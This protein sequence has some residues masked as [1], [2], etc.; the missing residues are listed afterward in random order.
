MSSLQGRF[1]IASPHLGDSN[2]YRSVVLMIHHDAE[3]AFGLVLNR[4][5]AITVGEHCLQLFDT[6]F[7]LDAPVFVGGPVPGPPLALHNSRAH[8]DEEVL[9]GVHISTREESLEPLLMNPPDQFRMF[10]GYSGWGAGQLEQEL[11]LGG[12][13]QTDASFSD[14]FLDPEVVWQ[15]LTR[16]INLDIRRPFA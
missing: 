3:G 8:S 13:L 9:P 12:W 11:E 16:R 5:L 2:F 6:D 14:V 4:P 7:E 10:D 1:L 15:Q